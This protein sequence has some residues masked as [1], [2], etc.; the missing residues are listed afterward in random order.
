MKKAEKPKSAATAPAGDI[1]TLP[2]VANYLNCHRIKVYRLVQRGEFPVFRL[3]SDYRFWRADIAAWIAPQGAEPK[4][5]ASRRGLH[6][7]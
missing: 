4:E 6:K 5:A 7:R 1:M 2:E 3:G